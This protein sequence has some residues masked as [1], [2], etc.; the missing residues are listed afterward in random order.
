MP[1]F[2]HGIGSIMGILVIDMVVGSSPV[3]DS[4]STMLLGGR[5]VLG[6]LAPGTGPSGTFPIAIGIGWREDSGHGRD[7]QTSRAVDDRCVP[8]H[9]QRRH[10]HGDL[11]D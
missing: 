8:G 11:P 5:L 7:R 1:P 2:V 6:L 10:Y 3:P 4:E 9:G